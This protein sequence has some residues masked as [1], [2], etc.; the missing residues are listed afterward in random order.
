MGKKKKE[1]EVKLPSI[2]QLP[3]GAWHTR[4][5]IGERRVSIT[6]D[7]Y[8]ACVSEYL[9]L[10]HGVLEAN[11]K[12]SKKQKTLSEAVTEYIDARVGLRSP[13]TIAGYRKDAK[14]T[15]R[16]AMSWN[17][18]TTSDAKWQD[19]IRQERKNGRSSKY[20]RNAWSLMAAA[21]EEATGTRPKVMLYPK[22]G[23]PREFLRPKQID[24]FVAAIK[25][26]PAEIPALLALSSL[27]KSELLALK[28]ENVDFEK[29]TIKIRGAVVRGESGFVEKPQNKTTKSQRT[30]PIIPPLMEALAAADRSGEYVVTIG[31]KAILS[32]IKKVCTDNGLPNVCLHGLRHSFASLAYHLQI[33]EMIAAEIGGWDDLATMHKIYT[34][35]AEDDIAERSKQ[36]VDYFSAGK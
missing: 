36:F 11:K 32:R 31:A 26:S 13:S 22:E 23:K 24:I 8:E 17:V 6:K 4:V 3:S 21:I 33:P 10:K 18:Y 25:G 16:Q 19:A 2:K 7:T 28:W 5:L 35:L 29:Q 30:I 1:P 27:R 9:A 15:F 12:R 20:I 14:N 34:H